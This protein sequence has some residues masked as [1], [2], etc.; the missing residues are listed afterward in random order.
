M[1]TTKQAELLDQMNPSHQKTGFEQW[2]TDHAP[3]IFKGKNREVKGGM[4]AENGLFYADH[5]VD[6]EVIQAQGHAIRR[7]TLDLVVK[8]RDITQQEICEI[9]RPQFTDVRSGL[10]E[11]FSQKKMH[12]P[13]FMNFF[14]LMCRKR[15]EI[16]D[17]GD[18][19]KI[20]AELEAIS[21]KTRKQ[22]LK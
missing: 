9:L 6:P 4:V 19:N 22:K 18:V 5:G 2:V 1:D 15:R 14:N 21:L 20:E 7:A 8:N 17:G 3:D 16:L 10:F 11:I 12:D 13:N